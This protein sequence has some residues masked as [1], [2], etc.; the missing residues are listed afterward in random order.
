MRKAT[1]VLAKMGL[2]MAALLVFTV[3]Q[4]QDQGDLLVKAPNVQKREV[5]AF[6][7][8]EVSNAIDLVLKQGNEDGVAVSATDADLRDRIVTKVENGVLKIYIDTKKFHWN[9]AWQDRKMKAF[10]SF[11]MLSALGASGSSDVYVDGSIRGD[12]LRID[13]SGSSDFKGG[14]NVRNLTLSQ[15]GSSDVKLTG[16]A[17]NI[18]IDLSGA[19]DVNAYDLTVDNCTVHSSGSSDVHITVNKEL[20]VEASGS[21]DVFYKGGAEVVKSRT[22]GSS[23]VSKKST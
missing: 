4:S 20:N 6:H 12:D 8:I 1:L 5:G 21:S 19:S 10:V 23:S 9:W 22:S 13:L 2:F 17:G 14:V 18:R 3:A 16:T 7:A 15:S 11:K